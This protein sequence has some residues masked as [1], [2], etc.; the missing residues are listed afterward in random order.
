MDYEYKVDVYGK[1]VARFSIGHEAIGLW[2]NEELSGN[3]CAI[4]ELLEFIQQLEQRRINQH[5]IQGKEFQLRL[6]W[7]QVEVIA[8]A[9]GIDVDE[10]L[11][12]DT[13]LYDQESFSECGLQDFKQAVQRWQAF[14]H[15]EV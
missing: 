4:A 2:L 3:K 9:L 13:H 7:D 12:E 14:I 6:S 1:P 10:D 5:H 11:P 8:L 15:S